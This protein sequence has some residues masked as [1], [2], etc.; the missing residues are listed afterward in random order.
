[1]E[2][3]KFKCES[4]AV[5]VEVHKIWLQYIWLDRVGEGSGYMFQL[6]EARCSDILRQM[7]QSKNETKISGLMLQYEK[8][9]RER[10]VPD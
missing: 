10:T 7:K 4:W 8:T 3:R 2:D 6:T 1:M 9:M 5:K